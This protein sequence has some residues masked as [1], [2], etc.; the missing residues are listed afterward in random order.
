MEGPGRM[1][2]KTALSG[3]GSNIQYY[4]PNEFDHTR[5]IS[6]DKMELDRR[7]YAAQ[8]DILMGLEP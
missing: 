4:K 2:A 5:G 1:D 8:R 3:N 7:R 6:L